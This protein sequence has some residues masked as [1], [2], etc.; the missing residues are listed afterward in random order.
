MAII[1]SSTHHLVAGKCTLGSPSYSLFLLIMCIGVP[2]ATL[3]SVPVTLNG[4]IC[5]TTVQMTCMITDLSSLRWSIGDISQGSYIYLPG[6]EL[7]V[8]LSS[9]PGIEISITAASPSNVNPD[10][11]DAT[12]TLTTNTTLLQAFNMQDFTCGTIGTRSAPVTV[13]FNLLG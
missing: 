10:L 11:F 3:S 4:D 13:N 7:P 8:T 1:L 5:H 9:Q 2:A 12:S 6:D